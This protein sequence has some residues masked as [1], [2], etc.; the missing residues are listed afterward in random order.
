MYDQDKKRDA[1]Y[2]WACERK[3]QR[4]KK[5]TARATTICIQ[6]QHK[7]CKFDA[8]H[9]NHAPETIRPGVLKA[10]TQ[11]KKLAQISTDQST[12]IISNVVATTSREIQPCLLQKEAL[13]QQIKRARYVC[14][15]EVEPNTLD[16]FQLP[17]A[18]STKLNG[19]DFVKDNK[20]GTERILLFTT[21]ENLK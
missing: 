14:D 18:H 4:D 20:D 13:R 21:S 11:M 15:E 8:K 17:D 7:I 2:D 6:N 3:D 16:N 12:Q 19:I 10:C 5:C 1:V 9:H